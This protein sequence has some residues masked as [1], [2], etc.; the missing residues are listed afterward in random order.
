MNNTHPFVWQLTEEFTAFATTVVLTSQDCSV[1]FRKRFLHPFANGLREIGRF[2]LAP[3]L[4]ENCQLRKHVHSRWMEPTCSRSSS[5]SSF[6]DGVTDDDWIP[7]FRLL[8]A[9]STGSYSGAP[10]LL[11]LFFPLR[12][13]DSVSD[14]GVPRPEVS[15]SRNSLFISRLSFLSR[16]RSASSCRSS[17]SSNAWNTDEK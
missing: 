10:I 3:F 13:R 5:S 1:T 11:L 9:G 14:I 8:P 2:R 6:I 12:P 7:R 16:A 15:V 4:A 17:P